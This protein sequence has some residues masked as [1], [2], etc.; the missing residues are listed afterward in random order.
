LE[1]F[2]NYRSMIAALAAAAMLSGCS[3]DLTETSSNLTSIAAANNAATETIPGPTNPNSSAFYV[4]NGAPNETISVYANGG[5]RYLR[6]VSDA[7][8]GFAFDTKG[9]LFVAGSLQQAGYPLNIYTHRGATRVQ[10][11]YQRQ[12]FSESIVDSNGNLF[13]ICAN[14]RVCEY[15]A[16][17]GTPVLRPH[18]GRTIQLN[19]HK[20][21]EAGPLALDSKGDLAV[22]NPVSI[23]VFPPKSTSPTW[24]VPLGG[25][26]V[27]ALAFDNS[28]NLY[29]AKLQTPSTIWVFAPGATAPTRTI[30]D[31]AGGNVGKLCFDKD[32]NLYVLS[33]DKQSAAISVYHAGGSQPSRVITDGLVPGEANDM[34]VSPLGEVFVSNVEPGN[35]V[36]YARGQNQ[37][38]RTIQN[39]L[40]TPTQ[41]G[42]SP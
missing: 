15:S 39:E 22:V 36:V 3:Q 35:V 38:L 6:S 41:I 34:V 17:H 2:V 21:Y 33:G 26:I 4:L 12:P 5:A 25:Y 37:P 1:L 18:V 29:V 20:Y 23:F 40:Y 13:N 9:H 14:A 32:N 7:L 16:A 30:E 42:F 24:S 27:T 28:G 19:S 11:I 10:T 8:Y 31:G